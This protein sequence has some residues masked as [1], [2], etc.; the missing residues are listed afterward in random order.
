M[1][2]KAFSPN[3][4]FKDS[5]NRQVH[6]VTVGIEIVTQRISVTT[7]RTAL[8]V[9]PLTNRQFCRIQNVGGA[10]VYI[11]GEDVNTSNGWVIPPY[12]VETFAIED[13][14]SIYGISGGSVDVIVMEGL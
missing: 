11:G 3:E 7:A 2:R 10:F 1:V 12:G 14:S 8:P 9:N 13:T 4:G 5:L 6:D